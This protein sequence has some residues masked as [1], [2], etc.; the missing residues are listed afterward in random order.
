MKIDDIISKDITDLSAL[1]I[2]LTLLVVLF[3]TILNRSLTKSDWPKGLLIFIGTTIMIILFL[4]SILCI[5]RVFKSPPPPKEKKEVPQIQIGK[6]PVSV[7]TCAGQPEGTECW[8]ELTNRPKCFVWNSYLYTDEVV[9]WTGECSEGFAQ[10]MGTLT[11]VWDNDK[12]T[13]KEIGYLQDGKKNGH[14]ILHR[15][16]NDTEQGPYVDGEKNGHWI[17]HRANNDIEQGPY[18]DGEKNGHWIFRLANG[19]LTQGLYVDGEKNSHWIIRFADGTVKQGPYVN[20][21]ENGPWTIR[22]ADGTVKQGPYVNGKENGPW[23]IR[24]A[25]GTVKNGLYKDGVYIKDN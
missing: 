6:L 17:L 19:I 10:G 13:Q 18:V 11:K 25:N 1:V 21:K 14:W 20:G 5:H 8:M 22:F 12:K 3:R 24:F 23:T 4:V 16:N 15:A 2:V 9:R 7:K